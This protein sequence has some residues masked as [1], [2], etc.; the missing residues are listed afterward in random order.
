MSRNSESSN[1]IGLEN[2]ILKKITFEEKIAGNDLHK[3][4]NFI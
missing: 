4:C 3:R 1:F 2:S